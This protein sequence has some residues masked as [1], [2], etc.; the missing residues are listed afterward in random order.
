MPM[1]P[2]P[3]PWLV[4]PAPGH[5]QGALAFL[6]DQAVSPA[7][8]RALAALAE[9]EAEFSLSA[10]TLLERPEIRTALGASTGPWL[11]GEPGHGGG[12]DEGGGLIA[13][14]GGGLLVGGEAGSSDEGDMVVGNQNGVVIA[15]N[16]G[17]AIVR[18]R[19]RPAAGR[20]LAQADANHPD[21]G[22]RDAALVVA[23]PISQV[24]I[25]ILRRAQTRPEADSLA[26]DFSMP[27]PDGRQRRLKFHV[28]G[29]TMVLLLSMAASPA[30]PAALLERRVEFQDGIWFHSV[31]GDMGGL[32]VSYS[33]EDQRGGGGY[34]EGPEGYVG[35][36]AVDPSQPYGPPPGVSEPYPH[37]GEEPY[38]YPGEEPNP[39]PGVEPGWDPD[40]E[41]SAMPWTPASPSPQPSVFPTPRPSP[42][43]Q[44]SPVASAP[45]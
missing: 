14:N 28:E 15:N 11:R 1:P 27:S 35:F 30:G 24:L 7:S 19:P 16:D 5:L 9:L 6:P 18:V 41:A 38:P 22:G 42:T 23:G 26:G 44:P 32:H 10:T 40:T 13:D 2:L 3:E 39:E 45:N 21:A 29:H 4:P 37:G 17:G 20:R 8:L 31:E 43:P 36:T 25:E 34:M 12:W 33:L